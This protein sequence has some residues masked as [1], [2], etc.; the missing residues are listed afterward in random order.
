MR[1]ATANQG[2]SPFAV[3]RSLK[4]RKFFLLVPILLLPPAAYYYAKRLPQTFRARALVG[5][6][7]LIPGEQAANNRVDPNTVSAQEELRA[8]RETL[9]N[10]PALD[11]VAQEADLPP[12]EDLKSKIQIQLDGPESFYIG[13][14]GGDPEQVAK[15]AN[16]LAG[17]FVERTSNLRDKQVEKQD[18]VLDGEVNRLRNQLSAQEEGLK[19]YKE[20]V[21]QELPERLATNL[22]ELENVQEQIRLKSDQ[23]TEG[24]ARISS[25]NEELK[26]LEKQGVMQEEPP[27]KTL[28]QVHLEQLKMN[29]NQLSARYTP[30]NPEIVRLKKEIRDL[31][32]VAAPPVKAA[33]HAATPAQLRYFALQAELKSIEPRLAN[34]R[35]E[36]AALTAQAH[37]YEQRVNASPGYET[38]L[39]ERTKDAAMLRSRYEAL[40]A[41]Q[42]EAKLNQRAEKSNDGLEFKILEPAQVPTAPSSPHRDRILLFGTLASLGLGLMGVF[43]AEQMDKTFESAEEFENFATIPVVSSIPAIPTRL[44]RQ[45]SK[46]RK[47]LSGWLPADQT[48]FSPQELKLFQKNRVVV[49]SDP[50]SVAS[51][52]YGILALKVGHWMRHKQGRILAVTSS[53]GEEGKSVTALNLSLALAASSHGRVLLI[54]GDLR[55]P[56]VHQ[57]LGFEPAMAFSDLLSGGTDVA[58]YIKKI[59]NLDVITG[60]SEPIN[61]VGLLAAPRTRE[62]LAQLREQYDLI[63]VDSPPLIPIADSHILAGLADGVLLVVRAR[64]T[65]PELFQRILKDLDAANVIGVV[66]NDVEFAA[67]PYAYAYHY[68]QRHYTARG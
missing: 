15:V 49:L 32:A 33:P 31:E 62:I 55:R 8:I 16:R 6:E 53:T 23:I 21:S 28:E 18:N 46:V 26:S 40:F 63:V 67:T 43:L 68:Y 38:A 51:Q 52:Q 7:P 3:L 54:D 22:K 44:P 13:F 50:Q 25:I 14:E 48:L 12:S 36:Q 24:Q 64:K 35:K 42:Q 27:A 58:S 41:K 20:R 11:T 1:N 34:Y 61:P 57:R 66:L 2:F 60:G 39:G 56:Q 19:A 47:S 65:H 37:D 45:M 29:L 5:A 17:L 9:F 4:R 30:E 10:S 59:G